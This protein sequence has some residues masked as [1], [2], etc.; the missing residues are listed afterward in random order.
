MQYKQPGG[1]RPKRQIRGI[2]KR[3]Y[4]NRLTIAYSLLAETNAESVA[5]PVLTDIGSV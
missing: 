3:L 1:D 4:M 2:I 5:L